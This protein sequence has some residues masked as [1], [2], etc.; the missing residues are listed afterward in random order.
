MGTT[1]C[2]TSPSLSP[3]PSISTFLPI[4][5][6]SP[7]PLISSL[8]KELTSIYSP[9]PLSPP[10]PSRYKHITFH[11]SPEEKLSQ[12]TTLYNLLL[13]SNPQLTPS[14]LEKSL[15]LSLIAYKS[16]SNSNYQ[17]LLLYN[18]LT[19]IRILLWEVSTYTSVTT[20]S[21]FKK[22][23]STYMKLYTTLLDNTKLHSHHI[24]TNIKEQI[25]KDISRT[26]FDY[27]TQ[28]SS[29]IQKLY[30]VLL[31]FSL[32]DKQ[33]GYCQGINFITKYIL[34]T[35]SYNEQLSFWLL[36]YICNNIRGFFLDEFP[37]LISYLTYFDIVFKQCLPKL[38]SHFHSLDIP[39]EVWAG[40]YIQTLFTM[41]T[42]YDVLCKI[43]D[44]LFAFGFEFIVFII[45][46]I[47]DAFSD[48]LMKFTENSDVIEFLKEV[49]MPSGCCCTVDVIYKKGKSEGVDVNVILRKAKKMYKGVFRKEKFEEVK[50][51]V[52]EERGFSVDEVGGGYY[53]R[54]NK[55]NDWVGGVS[56]GGYS[57]YEE[58]NGIR[59]GSLSDVGSLK[60]DEKVFVVERNNDK[61]RN[62]NN[63][64]ITNNN[65]K[66]KNK[67]MMSTYRDMTVSDEFTNEHND[68][69]NGRQFHI[70][71]LKQP[72]INNK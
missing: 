36:I 7:S 43:F 17:K 58:S 21:S 67:L 10:I 23:Q 57:T 26:F 8:H 49:L 51:K 31:V 11:S 61:S 39:H 15:T 64:D 48:E 33:L 53:E 24:N 13:S 3:K 25:T 62:R 37:L 29:S 66:S 34:E 45:L 54:Y 44:G 20:Y 1:S 38:Y 22:K 12:F 60:G 50:R 56:Y 9:S 4:L 30:N 41:C 42:S 28:S 18:T 68:Y 6:S 72:N 55:D 5:T 59:R 47:V 52:C 14:N 19:S 69:I 71:H 35:T 2:T 16:T 46:S 40:K 32:F 27:E 63:N 70:L 65:N